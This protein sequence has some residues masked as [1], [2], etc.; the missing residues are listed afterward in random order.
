MRRP[1]M[2][3]GATIGL[4]VV[5]GAAVVFASRFGVDPTLGP[6]PLVGKP[7]PEV[8]VISIDGG[9]TI[10]ISDYAGSV[11]VVNFWAPWC[12]PCRAEHA[13]LVAAAAEYRAAG[14]VVLGITYESEF[15]D[16]VE[17]LDEL[18]RGYPVAMDDR[19]RAAINFGV[20]GVPET[21][22]ID[23]DGTV[24]GKVS[25]PVDEAVMTT[26]LDAILIGESLE[27]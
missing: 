11:V 1:W 6:S 27:R 5:I 12:V 3:L 23:R 16:V 24:Y 19:S 18:G 10:Q 25:G 9:A 14:V 13:I 15:D 26:T 17:F 22:F 2:W 8:A 7:A 4:V 21:F 20:R